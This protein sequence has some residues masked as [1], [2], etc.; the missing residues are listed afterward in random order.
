MVADL[1]ELSLRGHLNSNCIAMYITLF[2]N[3]TLKWEREVEHTEARVPQLPRTVCALRLMNFLPYV[4]CLF[5]H[6]VCLWV[7]FSEVAIESAS[8]YLSDE[9]SSKGIYP[10]LSCLFKL[11]TLIN[12]H[13]STKP[14]HVLWACLLIKV[15][16][17]LIKTSS[18]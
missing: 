17:I 13:S 6:M 5:D 16:P 11:T 10:N 8:S 9:K 3:S 1:Q 12:V 2:F 14:R 7:G 4:S 15:S 18:V